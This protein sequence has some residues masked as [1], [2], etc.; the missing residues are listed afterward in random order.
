MKFAYRV[1][2][3]GDDTLLAVSDYEILGEKF[4]DKDLVLEA[5]REFYHEE[6]CGREEILELLESATVINAIGKNII[7]VL[8]EENIIEEEKVLKIGGVPH[9]QIVRI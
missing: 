3:E 7:N 6:V 9:A 4:E 8:V 1:Y 5:R 2:R